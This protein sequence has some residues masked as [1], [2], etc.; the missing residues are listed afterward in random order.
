M[1]QS[2]SAA[3]KAA[4]AAKG[5]GKTFTW[6]GKSYSTDLKEETLAGKK[7]KARPSGPKSGAT[8]SGVTGKVRTAPTNAVRP[9]GAPAG[10]PAAK[11]G[12]G[13]KLANV[14][15][16]GAKAAA[17]VAAANARGA[18]NAAALRAKKNKKG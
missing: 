9:A 15:R 2:F 13:A 1:A 12:A 11:T 16:Q 5:P 3:F 6:N 17:T 4:R 7:P 10:M 14:Q 18:A 8:Q